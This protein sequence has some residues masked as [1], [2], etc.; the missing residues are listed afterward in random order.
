MAVLFASLASGCFF[1]GATFD[2]A[3]AGLE[4]AGLRP[5]GFVTA[6][7]LVV[8]VA[9]LSFKILVHGSCI[10]SRAGLLRFLLS[11]DCVMDFLRFRFVD[12]QNIH[13]VFHIRIAQPFQIGKSRFD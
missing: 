4:A 2:L 8:L 13:Q 7:L 5:A 12:T 9:I 11:M 10:L 3:A 6:L 1:L